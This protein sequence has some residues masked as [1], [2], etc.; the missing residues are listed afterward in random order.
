LDRAY[1]ENKQKDFE[2]DDL[3]KDISGLS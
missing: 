2:L 1:K 3:K